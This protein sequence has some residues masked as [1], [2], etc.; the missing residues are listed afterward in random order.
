MR[1]TIGVLAHVD[2]GKTTFSEQILYHTQA[3]RTCG[4][5]DHQNTFLDGHAIERQ[6]G[7]TIFSDQAPF[8]YQGHEYTLI[9]T[10]GH[11]DFSAEMERS[12]QVMDCAVVVVSCVEGVQGHTR[13][14][15]KL[16]RQWGIPTLF[17]L[18]KMDR[19]GADPDGVMEQLRNKLSTG[20]VDFGTDFHHGRPGDRLV[21]QVAELDDGL[22]EKYLETGISERDFTAAVRNMVKQGQLFPCFVGS[23]LLD[24]GI[25]DFL[26]DLDFLIQGD[27]KEDPPLEGPFGGIVY[28]CRHDA[29]GNRVMFLKV[30]SGQLRAKDEIVCR[31]PDGNVR[32]EKINE[33]RLCHGLKYTPL[34]VA[35]AGDLCAVTGLSG[36]QPGDGVGCVTEHPHYQTTPTLS[37]KVLWGETVPA[38][39]VL[40]I[41]RL[42][43]EEDPMLHVQWEEEQGEIQVRIM[44]PIQL[45][46]LGAEVKQR[47]GL[48]V[49]FGPC[50]ILY[51]ET[52]ATSAVGYGHFEPL[53]HY[54]EVH[55]KLEP[56]RRGS[57][58]TFESRCSSDLL[59]AHYQRLIET[60]V[61]ERQHKGILTGSVLTDVHI[62]LLAGRAHLKH[63]EGGDFRQATYRAIRQGLEQAQPILLEPYYAFQVEAEPEQLGRILADAERMRC[64]F[65]PPELTEDR[66]VVTGR[67]P[68]STLMEYSRE[69]AA[70]TRGHGQISLTFDG[71]EPCHNTQEVVESIGYDKDRDV[72]NTSDSVFCSHGAGFPVKWYEVKDYIHIKG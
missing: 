36:I 65:D 51:R 34:D 35:K 32:R 44:G 45:E 42:L 30:T 5:V 58:I 4:R 17:F 18:N 61:F 64:Q 57:G 3:I 14:V 31:L 67:G 69:L 12:I 50:R 71:Y 72:Q 48:E 27:E 29:N 22:L 15:W 16:L 54:A 43:E 40:K 46:V 56:G 10:P 41:F 55:V 1:K 2:A 53:R 37:A 7:I 11:V 19:Q 21:E 24:Q 23:A 63:T 9:D 33:L 28:K 25:E 60:H 39:D 59:D 38:K 62:T 70:F 20:C 68:V 13:T 6:R 49:S 47:F 52:I 66:A 8:T 26:E